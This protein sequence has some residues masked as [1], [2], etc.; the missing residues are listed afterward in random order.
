LN[1]GSLIA[2]V[3]Q[4]TLERCKVVIIGFRTDARLVERVFDF[5]QVSRRVR[6]VMREKRASA[7]E[8]KLKRCISSINQGQMR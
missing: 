5:I 7:M 8:L 2:A 6:V 1:N 4:A 3:A